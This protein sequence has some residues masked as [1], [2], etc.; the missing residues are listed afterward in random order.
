VALLAV[1][2]VV[3]VAVSSSAAP[4]L[5][6]AAVAPVR[7]EQ[8]VD[9]VVPARSAAG[10]PAVVGATIPFWTDSVTASQNGKQY[11]FQMVGQD[12]TTQLSNPTTTIVAN[13]IPIV[14]KL[15]DGTTLD[16]TKKSWGEPA[17]PVNAVLASPVFK[18]TAFSAG[19][20]FVGNRYWN[21]VERTANW[22][23]FHA[24]L[25]VCAAWYWLKDRDAERWRMALWGVLAAA[26]VV[27]GWRFFPRYYFALLPVMALAGARGFALLGKR[28][29][30]VLPLLLMR[31]VRFGPRYVTLPR[32][33]QAQWRDAAMDQDSRAASAQVRNLAKPGD[34]LFV[35]GFRPEV[36]VYARLP[37]ATRFL[38]SQPLTGV[39]ADRH[40][41]QSVPSVSEWAARNRRAWSN[42]CKSSSKHM[43][44]CWSSTTW[45]RCSRSPTG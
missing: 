10:H 33:G 9:F 25:V 2:S 38:E 16:P 5:P 43:P 45:M 14:V 22:L 26:T 39:F 37:A 7:T 29:W 1:F 32:G 8:P 6:S 41:T 11:R 18:N 4:A 36:Y 17:S 20:T 12:P 3:G 24:A 13:I 44:C 35:W 28:R 30:L 31:L 40:L 19:D 15:A 23:G 27:A 42:C 34:T 21:G